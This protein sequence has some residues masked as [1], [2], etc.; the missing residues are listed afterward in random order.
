MSEFTQPGKS[1]FERLGCIS[2]PLRIRF[3]NRFAFD[4]F[5]DTA[6]ARQKKRAFFAASVQLATG[7]DESGAADGRGRGRHLVS[8]IS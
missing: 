5:G 4:R 2:N 3:V 6:A 1:I 7:N 8:V